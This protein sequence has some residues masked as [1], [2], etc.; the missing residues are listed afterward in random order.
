[1]R[2]NR[3]AYTTKQQQLYASLE[4]CSLATNGTK[5]VIAAVAVVYSYNYLLFILTLC[6]EKDLLFGRFLF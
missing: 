5:E 2:K 4:L 3:D 6:R 1:M